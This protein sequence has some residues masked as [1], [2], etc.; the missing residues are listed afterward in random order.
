MHYTAYISQKI[1]G[2]FV[3]FKFFYTLTNMKMTCWSGRH[4]GA[5]CKKLEIC[6][7]AKYKTLNHVPFPILSNKSHPAS[8]QWPLTDPFRFQ[9]QTATKSLRNFIKCNFNQNL[10]FLHFRLGQSL[11]IFSFQ[12]EIHSVFGGNHFRR[13]WWKDQRA[14]QAQMY[15][16]FS[17]K[18]QFFLLWLAPLWQL[19]F[20]QWC[21]WWLWLRW[22]WRPLLRMWWWWQWR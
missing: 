22:R 4:P 3:N 14:N 13:W 2:I 15:F 5:H 18:S 7:A 9:Q 11:Q 12:N 8:L 17:I 10:T 6:P 1:L 20:L 16:F 19:T 21:W